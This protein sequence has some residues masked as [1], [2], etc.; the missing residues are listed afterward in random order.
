MSFDLKLQTFRNNN[1]KKNLPFLLSGG[2]FLIPSFSLV[3]TLGILQLLKNISKCP[4]QSR[5][6]TG[7]LIFLSSPCEP[8]RPV[9]VTLVSLGRLLSY[10]N[11]TEVITSQSQAGR[12]H[13]V[14]EKLQTAPIE[15]VQLHEHHSN[16]N[17]RNIT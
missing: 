8:T 11:R 1:K 9:F 16:F 10:G 6:K 3:P 4:G 2:V 14:T 13:A 5:Y 7:P 17:S 15:S 12:A